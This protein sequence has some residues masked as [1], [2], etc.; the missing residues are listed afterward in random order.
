[1]NHLVEFT[2]S[3]GSTKFYIESAGDAQTKEP[4]GGLEKA[5]LKPIRFDSVLEKIK[6]FSQDIIDFI[7]N[8][9]LKPDSTTLEFGFSIAAEGNIFIAKA[10][11][12]ASVKVT[13]NWHHKKID[14]KKS[15]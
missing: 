5:G 6:P 12:E 7:T 13:M 11:G 1:M 4:G 15:N 14:L 9:N 3:D 2:S 10:S 8:H